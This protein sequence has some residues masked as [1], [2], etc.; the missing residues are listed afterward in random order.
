MFNATNYF[1]IKNIV[2]NE[3]F[4]STWL[5]VIVISLIGI[6]FGVKYGFDTK[7]ILLFGFL[8]IGAVTTFNNATYALW[9]FAVL[10]AT[11]IIYFGVAKVL[12]K[13]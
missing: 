8:F 3:L 7:I 12:I 11:V 1:D 2:V 10:I 13:R 6:Y 4:G 9:V 5:F